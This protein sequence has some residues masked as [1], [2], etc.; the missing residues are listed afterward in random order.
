ML[1]Q[2]AGSLGFLYPHNRFRCPHCGKKI[3]GWHRKACRACGIPIGTPKSAM[4]EAEKARSAALPI[5]QA[6]GSP[7]LRVAD[8]DAGAVHAE[9]DAD[10]G[11]DAATAASRVGGS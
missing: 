4:I 9:A 2:V 5:E 7:G 11:A 8:A 6:A 1:G 3:V 10:A